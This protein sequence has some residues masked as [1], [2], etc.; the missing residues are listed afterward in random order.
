MITKKKKTKTLRFDTDILEQLE[1]L[2]KLD[3]RSLNNLMEVIFEKYCKDRD[4]I[5][6]KFHEE[7]YGKKEKKKGQGLGDLLDNKPG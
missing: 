7:K 6:Q 4:S 1:Y 3:K 5:L 2:A